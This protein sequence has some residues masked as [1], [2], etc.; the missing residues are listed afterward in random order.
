MRQEVFGIS[1]FAVRPTYYYWQE[2]REKRNNQEFDWD[3]KVFVKLDFELLKV[4]GF[5][6]DGTRK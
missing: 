3:S 4:V 6:I 5:G 2:G 1:C